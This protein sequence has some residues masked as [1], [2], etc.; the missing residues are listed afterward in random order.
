MLAGLA[1]C[2]APLPGEP[3]DSSCSVTAPAP[4][5]RA[6]SSGRNRLLYTL[7]V[8]GLPQLWM[9][10]LDAPAPAPVRIDATGTGPG[11]LFPGWERELGAAWSPAGGLVAV[12]LASGAFGPAPLGVIDVNAPGTVR[13]VGLRSTSATGPFQRHDE[14]WSPDGARLVAAGPSGVPV[15][16]AQADGSGVTDLALDLADPSAPKWAPDGRHLGVSSGNQLYVTPADV[17]APQRAGGPISFWGTAGTQVLSSLLDGAWEVFE[18]ELGTGDVVQVDVDF[19]GFP[20]LEYMPVFSADGAWL[21]LPGAGPRILGRGCSEPQA[22]APAIAGDPRA[23]ADG[24]YIVFTGSS[25]SG[26]QGESSAWV[27]ELKHGAWEARHVFT[28]TAVPI[29]AVF[30]S[31]VAR[32]RPRAAWRI[33]DYFG[34]D[35]FVVTDDHLVDPATF[36][37]E[38]LRVEEFVSV[39]TYWF[40]GELERFAYLTADDQPV[41]RVIDLTDRHAPALLGEL[42]VAPGR[43]LTRA[44]WSSD[45][46]A[47]AFAAVDAIAGTGVDVHVA[48]I[49]NG[50][51]EAPQLLGTTRNDPGSAFYWE[52]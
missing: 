30:Q 14:V 3:G 34:G 12:R 1:A 44:Q 17:A 4:P 13:D 46:S 31:T 38:G 28:P 29:P 45:G 24:R 23:T 51:L 6:P 19:A 33:G 40:S 11:P 50:V 5:A 20:A 18:A 48:R 42:S 27:A 10:D 16:V 52:P 26:R 9:L 2:D 32:T 49:R 8:D 22:L 35:T 25:Q 41:L 43:V 37:A 47:L 7:A 21:M 36:R 15:L 39:Q